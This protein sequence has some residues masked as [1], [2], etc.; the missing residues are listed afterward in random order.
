MQPMKM[1][2][3]LGLTRLYT[4]SGSIVWWVLWLWSALLWIFLAKTCG[5]YGGLLGCGIWGTHTIVGLA[6]LFEAIGD[7]Q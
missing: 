6:R 4:E 5:W 7:L 3:P 1:L 2:K